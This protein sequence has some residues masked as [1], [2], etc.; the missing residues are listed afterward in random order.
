MIAALTVCGIQEKL[1]SKRTIVSVGT[2]MALKP[3]FINHATQCEMAL[4]LCKLC[5]NTRLHFDSIMSKERKS[6]GEIFKSV[7]EFLPQN[8][9]VNYHQMVFTN[10]HVSQ[11]N[12][13]N[14]L[15]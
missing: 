6:G 7:T 9:I 10:G 2:L 3:F 8:V 5:L 13:S 14:A 1:K 12:A 4:C 15:K 11:E